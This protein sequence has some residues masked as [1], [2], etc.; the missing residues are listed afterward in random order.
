LKLPTF[1]RFLFVGL[2]MV[3]VQSVD[4]GARAS[5]HGHLGRYGYQGCDTGGFAGDA[6]QVST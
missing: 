3:D 5:D 6:M 1:V 4:I 2:V